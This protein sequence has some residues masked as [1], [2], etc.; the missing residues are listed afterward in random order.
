MCTADAVRIAAA[1]LWR[2]TA[3]PVGQQRHS[4]S[5]CSALGVPVFAI[6]TA[7]SALAGR[8]AIATGGRGR[9]ISVSSTGS[10]H[11]RSRAPALGLLT[12]SRPDSVLCFTSSGCREPLPTARHIHSKRT[13]GRDAGT[14]DDRKA[15]CALARARG[16]WQ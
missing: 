12:E 6:A 16:L 11:T 9:L 3:P 13:S 8:P 10:R 1:T 4:D 7:L 15:T 5:S 2:T 14:A